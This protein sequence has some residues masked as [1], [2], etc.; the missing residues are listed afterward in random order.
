MMKHIKN[1]IW[2]I[3]ISQ[4]YMKGHNPVKIFF[5]SLR[6]GFFFCQ[7]MNEAFAD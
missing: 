7:D 2:F 1:Y 4:Q 5:Q 6:L 3:R